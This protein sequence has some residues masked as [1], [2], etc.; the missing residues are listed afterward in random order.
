MKTVISWITNLH[1]DDWVVPRLAKLARILAVAMGMMA[2]VEAQKEDYKG[3]IAA[4]VLMQ[5][6]MLDARK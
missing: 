2:F 3:A 5:L 1:T 4:L 6:M